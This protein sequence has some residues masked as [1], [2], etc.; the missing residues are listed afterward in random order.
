M[1]A[2]RGTDRIEALLIAPDVCSESQSM[3]GMEWNGLPLPVVTYHSRSHATATK[4]QTHRP[5]TK[6][7]HQ[8]KKNVT[9]EHP[10]NPKLSQVFRVACVPLYAPQISG[11]SMHT[12]PSRARQCH[13][14]IPGAL[15]PRV[16]ATNAPPP[17]L[18]PEQAR[19]HDSQHSTAHAH[20]GGPSSL[21]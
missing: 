3:G 15:L 8:N 5:H 19:E 13:A 2:P 14:C 18:W 21:P 7:W 12:V 10:Q 4:E 16:L 1:G 11:P 17:P 9:K 20:I 6:K